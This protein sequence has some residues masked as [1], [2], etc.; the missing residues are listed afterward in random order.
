MD[1]QLKRRLVGAAVIM[2]LAVVVVPLFFEDKSPKDPSTLPEAMQEHP[3]ALPPSDSAGAAP[4]VAEE[5][6]PVPTPTASPKKRKYEVVPLDDTPAKPVQ[7][8][9]APQD[10]VPSAV[11][12]TPVESAPYSEDEVEDSAPA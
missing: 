11:S 5:S 3:L 10:P 4:S 1:E 6:A 8:E 2:L 9:P 12:T 7:D